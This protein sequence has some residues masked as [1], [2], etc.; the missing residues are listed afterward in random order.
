MTE[1]VGTPYF[2]APEVLRGGHT[3]MCDMW[4]AGVLL[5]LLLIGII[6]FQNINI[7]ILNFIKIFKNLSK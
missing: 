1:K 6:F 2:V 4:S 7:L 3:E 5:Y